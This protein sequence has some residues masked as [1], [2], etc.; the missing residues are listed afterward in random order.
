MKKMLN[1]LK[2]EAGHLM[3]IF[4]AVLMLC[5]ITTTFFAEYIIETDTAKKANYSFGLAIAIGVVFS[6]VFEFFTFFAALNRYRWVSIACA[7]LSAVFARATFETVEMEFNAKY[8]AGWVM[9]IFPSFLIAFLSHQLAERFSGG[10]GEKETITIP[11]SLI[12]ELEKT[13]SNGN[14]H[15][16]NGNGKK[17]RTDNKK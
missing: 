2:T 12:A 13:H 7:V 5:F 14:G 9:T 8:L 4:I 11:E 6:I 17:Q 15:G 16:G 1:F 3:F 10:A